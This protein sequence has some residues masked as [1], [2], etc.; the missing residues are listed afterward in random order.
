MP[1]NVVEILIKTGAELSG[2]K[3]AADAL[4]RDIGKA[5][6]LGK[7]YQTLAE[8]LGRARA[9]IA[10]Y[11]NA[12]QK[13]GFFEVIK[14]HLEEII[15][16]FS[17]LESVIGK[18]V[19]GPLGILAAGFAGLAGA[20]D[21]AKEGLVEYAKAE[22]GVAKMDAALAQ[23][24]LLSE[25]SRESL[26]ELAK[27]MQ[28]LTTI[29]DD[30][31]Y[32]VLARLIQFGADTSNINKYA[33]AV[34][35]L[36]GILG[37]DIQ[38][39]ANLVSRAMQGHFEMFSRYGYVVKDAGTQT[40][41]LET[42]FR[43][44]SE[45]GGGQLEAMGKSLN[46]QWRDVKNT[47]HDFTEA[48]GRGIASTGILQ[49]IMGGVG[50]FFK[51]WAELLGGVVP[52]VD[53]LENAVK[54]TTQTIEENAEKSKQKL[55]AVGDAISAAFQEASKEIEH[56]IK[57]LEIAN[58]S[59]EDDAKTKRDV[60]LEQV[61]RGE[62][63]G[64]SL[65]EQKNADLARIQTAQYAGRLTPQQADYQRN[66]VEKRYAQRH[67]EA[68]IET[69]AVKDRA[70]IEKWYQ[71]QLV[72]I[73]TEA[74]AK[75]KAVLQ[76]QLRDLKTLEDQLK[77]IVAIEKERKENADKKEAAE[78]KVNI[79]EQK[80]EAAKLAAEKAFGFA[81]PNPYL[82]Q[83]AGGS[84]IIA[85]AFANADV[86]AAAAQNEEK[87]LGNVKGRAAAVA[88]LPTA[89]AEN[90]AMTQEQLAKIEKLDEQLSGEVRRSVEIKAAQ[91]KE[92]QR[93]NANSLDV[94]ELKTQTDI[95]EKEIALTK[96]I[97]TQ[98]KNGLNH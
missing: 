36:A 90:L 94:L 79:Q 81:V 68:L 58:K 33:D 43:Q 55:K 18:I 88:N 92:F 6:A 32:P 84:P 39:S 28:R 42:L 12:Q 9:V 72:A 38:T 53:G 2:A 65:E 64:K 86:K 73:R 25:E 7:E 62:V 85:G 66:I 13:H 83:A 48:I 27:E 1:D 74:Y 63:I 98:I 71:E 16:G 37:G 67:P 77:K 20:I 60:A 45:R 34:K 24:G 52:Q 21:L 14:E 57:L 93:A 41:K 87:I 59:K 30:E 50:N 19:S 49:S 3:A 89:G 46:G 8:K 17:R 69:Q 56:T 96:S 4:E 80:T 35:N 5:K 29:A 76:G 78:H 51:G 95:L 23:R 47:F 11:E 26:H 31:W 91:I 54:S 61:R 22:E 82:A 97:L 75:E 10:E 15:P 40:E 70:A 44:L